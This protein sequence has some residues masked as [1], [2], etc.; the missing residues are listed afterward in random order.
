MRHGLIP[1]FNTV[2]SRQSHC[3]NCCGVRPF[4]FL[5]NGTAVDSVLSKSGV[6]G[7]KNYLTTTILDQLLS[8]N[9]QQKETT[10]VFGHTHKPFQD[11]ISLM[12]YAEPVNVF[13]T[14]GWVLDNP[15]MVVTQGAALVF[16][17]QNLQ[18]ASLRLFNNNNGE[19]AH[20]VYAAGVGGYPDTK[21]Q[22]LSRLNQAVNPDDWTK[23]CAAFERG[24][25]LR[26][27]IAQRRFFNPA[28]NPSSNGED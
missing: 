11:R 2:F 21:N 9:A 18:A 28:T 4:L 16:I 22:M 5:L 14:G 19:Q 12:G 25:L 23:F 8:K 1:S 7:L 15:D 27:E 13:N 24:V 6:D 10:F 26:A 20:Q 17:D 3:I